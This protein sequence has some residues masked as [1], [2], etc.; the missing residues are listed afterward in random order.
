[1]PIK[2]R[3]FKTRID[4]VEVEGYFEG[5]VFVFRFYEVVT[6]R[7]PVTSIE[8]DARGKFAI[9][10]EAET[11][12][13]DGF[14]LS[15]AAEYDSD[16]GCPWG[17]QVSLKRT[18]ISEQHLLQDL[19]KMKGVD[20]DSVNLIIPPRQLTSVYFN[21]EGVIE[22]SAQLRPQ[23]REGNTENLEFDLIT[24]R[25]R[26]SAA[27]RVLFLPH[28]VRQMSRPNRMITTREIRTVIGHGEVIENYPDD[29]R[30]PSCLL[31]G[32]GTKDRAIHVVCSPHP[33]FLA[34]ITAYLPDQDKWSDDFRVRKNR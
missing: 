31:L 16:L 5:D 27:Q 17:Y 18:D 1:M 22:G 24:E 26:S 2:A 25:I 9:L 32:R 23:E 19:L 11:S 4:E 6:F 15:V 10:Q 34:I 7:P 30:G 28:A 14:S 13:P 3:P 29:P 8:E 20:P 33:D 12:H 21:P